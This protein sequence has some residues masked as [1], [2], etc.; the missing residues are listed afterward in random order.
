M[1]Y[2]FTA[3]KNLE[4]LIF[5]MTKHTKIFFLLMHNFPGVSQQMKQFIK[6]IG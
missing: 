1:F 6:K 4:Q 3:F 2:L 5:H